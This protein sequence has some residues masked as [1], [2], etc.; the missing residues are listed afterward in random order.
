MWRVH[1]RC[2]LLLACAAWVF[3]VY[4]QDTR[5]LQAVVLEPALSIDTLAAKIANQRVI[6]IGE[7]HERY[8][9]HLN[10]LAIIRRLH[11]LNPK[12]V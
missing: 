12:L 11:Q 10:Q 1:Y 4:A 9:H 3:P 6:F 7:T 8:D 5:P 2:L